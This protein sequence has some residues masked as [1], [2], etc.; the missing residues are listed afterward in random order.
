MEQVKARADLPEAGLLEQDL[1]VLVDL[2]EVDPVVRVGR[3]LRAV[4]AVRVVAAEVPAVV[5]P[6]VRGAQAVAVPAEAA[7]RRQLTRS[8]ILRMARFP[9]MRLLVR[10]PTT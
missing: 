9:T 1:A 8:S 3:L 7:A 4:P 5:V 6:V 10:N 2:L